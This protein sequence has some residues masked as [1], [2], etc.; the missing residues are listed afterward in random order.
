M[1]RRTAVSRLFPFARIER[2]M[3]DARIR[4]AVDAVHARHPELAEVDIAWFGQRLGGDTRGRYHAVGFLAD[5]DAGLEEGRGFVVDVLS[6][7]V[8]LEAPLERRRDLPA[9]ISALG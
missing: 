5:A 9:H 2:E 4:A 1:E 6:G 7:H 3:A 8:L